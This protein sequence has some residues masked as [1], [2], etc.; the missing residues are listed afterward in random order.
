[1]QKP[2]LEQTKKKKGEKEMILYYYVLWAGVGAALVLFGENS[3]NLDVK[4]IFGI[5]YLLS[6]IIGYGIAKIEIKEKVKK[7]G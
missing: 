1:M 5:T 6:S 2:L 7:N 4:S 3:F